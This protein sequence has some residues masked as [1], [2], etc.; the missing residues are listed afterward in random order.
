MSHPPRYIARVNI[1]KPTPSSSP[2]APSVSQPSTPPNSPF[3]HLDIALHPIQNP[4][5][6]RLAKHGTPKCENFKTLTR[7][8]PQIPGLTLKYPEPQN[9]PSSP[10]LFV[11]GHYSFFLRLRLRR[12][13]SRTARIP[14]RREFIQAPLPP[15]IF[16]GAS[17]PKISEILKLFRPPTSIQM[18]SKTTI[19]TQYHAVPT[20]RPAQPH[21]RD[22]PMFHLSRNPSIH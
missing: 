10:W 11:R 12:L 14:S 18:N 9:H 13:R 6:Q 15:P 19:T 1:K 7:K 16:P 5:L 4:L 20:P 17:P 8:Y 3:F 22:A 2:S 21:L